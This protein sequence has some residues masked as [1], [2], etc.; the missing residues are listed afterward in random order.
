MASQTL[1][2]RPKSPALSKNPS[3]NRPPPRY[4]P[5]NSSPA[6]NL[7]LNTPQATGRDKAM[8]T[9]SQDKIENVMSKLETLNDLFEFYWFALDKVDFTRESLKGLRLIIADC[10]A[11]LK[12]AIE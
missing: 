5:P 8:T 11:E 1:A 3:E 2:A 7:H 9:N 10:I 4:E 6:T 12:E